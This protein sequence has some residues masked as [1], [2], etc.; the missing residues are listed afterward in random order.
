MMKYICAFPHTYMT[1]QLLHSEFPYIRHEEN[2]IW[3]FI[4]VGTVCG[5][6]RCKNSDDSKKTLSSVRHCPMSMLQLSCRCAILQNWVRGSALHLAQKLVCR[7]VVCTC[8]M[9]HKRSVFVSM[10][11]NFAWTQ[12]QVV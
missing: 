10:P 5:S 9:T 1:V 6:A 8:K 7:Q 2:L 12:Q 4:S 11:K 3:F